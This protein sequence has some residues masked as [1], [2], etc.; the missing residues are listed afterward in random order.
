MF[1]HTF[2]HVFPTSQL[3]LGERLYFAE[4]LLCCCLSQL[5][6]DGPF[7]LPLLPL[8][9]TA[10]LLYFVLHLPFHLLLLLGVSSHLA[11]TLAKRNTS[12]GTPY[13]MAPVSCTH[14]RILPLPLLLSASFWTSAMYFFTSHLKLPV[15]ASERM[16]LCVHC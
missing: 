15:T 10:T 8:P 2:L 4:K 12:V 7:P 16:C 13:W 14:Q 1:H 5:L 3:Q 9:L 6:S 11:N